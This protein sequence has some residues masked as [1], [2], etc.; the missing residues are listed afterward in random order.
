[1]PPRL[2]I[3]MATFD[4]FDGVYFS[5]QALRMYHSEVINDIEIIV[6][7]NNPDGNHGQAIRNL[8]DQAKIKYI[9]FGKYKS[10][11]VRNLIFENASAPYVVSMD[12]HVLFE[13]GSLKKL[14]EYYEQ[15]P[16]TEDLL[17]GPMMY[18]NLKS[19]ASHFDPVWRAQMFGIWA[20]DDRA[21][22]SGAEPFEI[23]MQGLGVFSAKKDNWL[24]FNPNFRG[25]G[26]EEG[27]IHE[28]YRQHGAKTLCL[29]FLRWLHRFQ[30][31]AGIN[32]DLTVASKVRNYFI[33]CIEL[34]QDAEPIYEHFIEETKINRKSLDL[35][36]KQ[37][38]KLVDQNSI[39]ER[40]VYQI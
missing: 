39:Q 37:A 26:G 11:A 35:L 30:R 40:F 5:V 19:Y 2:T 20:T 31:P 15:N 16:D 23:P 10:T 4:D 34:G 14:L 32:Y 27:Y 28:K 36:Y 25:F 33:G 22:D 18:D 17:Q 1:M 13:S 7:D 24:G 6:I 12:C 21:R 38:E 29:P 8:K 3:G 9:P